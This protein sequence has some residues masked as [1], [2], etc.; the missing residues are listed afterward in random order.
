VARVPKQYL[1]WPVSGNSKY[2]LEG[3]AVPLISAFRASASQLPEQPWPICRNCG[4]MVE[5]LHESQQA[6][7]WLYSVQCS[8][9]PE[10]DEIV[11]PFRLVVAA[12]QEWWAAVGWLRKRRLSLGQLQTAELAR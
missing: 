12:D 9:S 3:D 4:Q 1:A 6:E 11:L 7:G 5:Q 10:F 8:C 2:W